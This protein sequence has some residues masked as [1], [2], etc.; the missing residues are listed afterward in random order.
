MLPEF[1]GWTKRASSDKSCLGAKESVNKYVLKV[2]Q[3]LFLFLC[4]I[5]DIFGPKKLVCPDFS[6]S[7]A[8]SKG[9][10]S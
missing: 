9:T 7:I 3:V 10:W 6:D 5:C 2:S 4:V 8:L 1:L